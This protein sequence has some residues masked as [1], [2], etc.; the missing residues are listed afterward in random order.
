M[1]RS[2]KNF[3]RPTAKKSL[4]QHF[5]TNPHVSERIAMVCRITSDD[6]VLEIGPGKG[7]LTQQLARY[8]QHLYA[9]E[10]DRHLA[11][12]LSTPVAELSIGDALDYRL[13]PAHHWI[14][15]GNLPYNI[16]VPIIFHF[17]DQA[18]HI[19][20]MIVMVQK[21]VALR[22]AA[23][24]GSK[25]YGIPSVVLQAEA[26]VRLLFH[27]GPGNFSPKPKVEST[28][29]EIVP[30]ASPFKSEEERTRFRTLVKQAFSQRRKM[31]ANTLSRYRFS[32]EQ[33][34]LTGKERAEELSLDTYLALAHV[35]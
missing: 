17:L 8:T 22:L 21:E 34:G 1:K 4:G 18:N 19:K 3:T 29:I 12:A 13:D 35:I 32:F 5:L 26:D 20:R 15:T 28:V 23:A 16:S 7:A 11:T 31:I 2:E 24:H 33:F 9:V 10:K 27:I 25:V 6:F 30:R 14:V